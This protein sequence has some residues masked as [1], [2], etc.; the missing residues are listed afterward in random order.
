[1]CKDMALKGYELSVFEIFGVSYVRLAL[2]IRGS[3]E[4]GRR[5]VPP[6]EKT[7]RGS[8]GIEYS[9]HYEG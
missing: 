3:Q 7:I 9:Y 1:M 4:I 2:Y 6:I 5:H 8:G